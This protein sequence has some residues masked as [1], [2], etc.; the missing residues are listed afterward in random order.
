MLLTLLAVVALF[1]YPMMIMHDVFRHP[2]RPVPVQV[3]DAG[4]TF[5]GV[6]YVRGAAEPREVG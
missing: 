5:T 4:M 1:A 3:P 6:P 2:V